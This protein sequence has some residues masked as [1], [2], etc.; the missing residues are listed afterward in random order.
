MGFKKAL[1]CNGIWISSPRQLASVSQ[2]LKKKKKSPK[3]RLIL[4][5]GNPEL[6][7]TAVTGCCWLTETLNGPPTAVTGC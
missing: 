6:Y 3:S 5:N 2:C 7:S 1:F 4:A